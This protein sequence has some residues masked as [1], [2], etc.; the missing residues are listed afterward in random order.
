MVYFGG[1]VSGALFFAAAAAAFIFLSVKRKKTA[2]C[3]AGALF[4]IV[5]MF[6][7][8]RLYLDPIRDYAGKTLNAQIQVLKITERSGQSEELIAKANLGGRTTKLRLSC[9]E[10]LPDD[11]IADVTIELEAADNDNFVQDLSDGILLSG[12]ITEICSAEYA[13]A[14]I[15]SVFR[16]IH[17]SFYGR[18]AENVFGESREFA[19]AML[20]GDDDKLSAKNAEYLRVSGAAHYTAVSGAHFAVLAA[21]LL[22]LI[23]QTRRKTRITV[24][25]MFAPAGLLFYGI[26]PSVLRASVMFLLYSTGM[27]LHRKSDPL[28]SA[29]LL[30]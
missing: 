11:H 15:Y 13:G 9:A 19:A 3:A 7:Y 22:I 12:E 23:P 14:S 24:S 1:G 21:A 25:L 20:F 26:S 17:D 30:R 27:L 28:N 4:G 29:L 18:L 16:V 5:L 6:A 2:L 10:A 8:T